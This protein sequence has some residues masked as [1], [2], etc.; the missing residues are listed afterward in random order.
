MSKT[1][2]S[3]NS[4]A[5]RYFD[6]SALLEG[7]VI[8]NAW[9]WEPT[10]GSPNNDSFSVLQQLTLPTKFSHLP[11]WGVPTLE[12]R[13]GFNTT[14]EF[15]SHPSYFVERLGVMVGD[16]GSP[17]LEDFGYVPQALVDYI[18]QRPDI[19]SRFPSGA[20]LLPGGPSIY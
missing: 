6:I 7:A 5:Q 19:T 18:T 11:A 4:F 2:S 1:F 14:I 13:Y 8:L 15:L 3:I 10:K 9:Q 17:E 16:H 12:D 20:S